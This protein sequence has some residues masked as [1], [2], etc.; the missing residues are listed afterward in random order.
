MRYYTRVL[1]ISQPRSEQIFQLFRMSRNS[2]L[3]RRD[4]VVAWL[5]IVLLFYKRFEGG[6]GGGGGTSILV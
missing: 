5:K 6:G 3:I 2:S 4:T 1:Y